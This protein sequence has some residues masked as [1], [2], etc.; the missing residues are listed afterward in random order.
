[1]TYKTG[2]I[3]DFAK[4][5]KRVATSPAASAKTPKRWFDSHDP[6]LLRRFAPRNDEVIG[7]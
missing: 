6:G 1:M 4:W 7:A 3:G 2:S 5:T